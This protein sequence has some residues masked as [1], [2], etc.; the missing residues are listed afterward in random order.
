MKFI[1]KF[2]VKVTMSIRTCLC[3][4]KYRLLLKLLWN[5][6]KSSVFEGTVYIP[7]VKGDIFVG[8]NVRFGP[9]IR[10]GATEGANIHIGDNVSINQGSFII[11]RESIII[12]NNTRV[13][14]YV[15][16]RDNDHEWRNKDVSIMDQGFNTKPVVIGSDVW[17]GRN[18]VISKGVKIGRGSVIGA[19]AVI[20]KD[21]NE[22]EV[23]V[24]NPGRVIKKRGN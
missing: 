11:A 8:N 6:G 20:T 14:E 1:G 7:A 17:I 13:G 4:L 22:Y 24:G 12:G 18:V 3:T 19:N 15:S 9:L 23:V 16:I 21:V 10:I 2:I 5:I